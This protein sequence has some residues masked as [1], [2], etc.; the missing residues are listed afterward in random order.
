MALCR[1]ADRNPPVSFSAMGL[2]SSGLRYRSLLVSREEKRNSP[3]FPRDLRASSWFGKKKQ[4]RF[5]WNL[6]QESTVAPLE[7][8]P[9]QPGEDEHPLAGFG[10]VCNV[11]RNCWHEDTEP[12][13]A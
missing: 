5:H 2:N 3:S 1:K 9:A 13:S 8:I 10:A 4:E 7:L 6:L 12:A 11:S